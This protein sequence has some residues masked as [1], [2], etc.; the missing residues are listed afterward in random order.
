VKTAST[1][2]V[3]Y[4]RLYDKGRPSARLRA[5][6]RDEKLGRGKTFASAKDFMAHLESCVKKSR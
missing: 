2:K 4:A 1:P 3:D 6:I 5:V